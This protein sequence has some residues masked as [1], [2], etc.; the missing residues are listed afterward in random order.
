MKITTFVL[1]EEK[2]KSLGVVQAVIVLSVSCG[3][4]YALRMKGTNGGIVVI[5]K[6]TLGKRTF[7]AFVDVI[8][9]SW[10]RRTLKAS[11]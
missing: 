7:D 11:P 3:K 8:Y 5:S 9:G 1:S 2:G 4:G 6:E 10:N